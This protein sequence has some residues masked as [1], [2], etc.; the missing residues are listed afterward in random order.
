MYTHDD[1]IS[2]TK[3]YI[4]NPTVPNV[5][6]KRK[7]K[8][9]KKEKRGIGI[10]RETENVEEVGRFRGCYLPYNAPHSPLV[11]NNSSPALPVLHSH[12]EN[13]II[14]SLVRL[15]VFWDPCA[16][17]GW[18]QNWEA[19]GFGQGRRGVSQAFQTNTCFLFASSITKRRSRRGG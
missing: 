13:R 11:P 5:K 8:K 15:Y 10:G 16:L 1:N 19:A 7:E 9:R 3:E 2:W 17:R 18:Y 12:P 6:K 14:S 4:S